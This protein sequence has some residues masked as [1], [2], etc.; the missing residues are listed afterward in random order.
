MAKKTLI[1][2]LQAVE[3][4]IVEL[5]AE[6][7]KLAEQIETEKALANLAAGT[8]I[9][10]NYGRADTRK[11]LQGVVKGVADT[12]KGRRIKVESGEGFDAEIYII[13]VAA[14]VKVVA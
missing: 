5:Q 10:F 11:E 12:D 3:A 2:Q 7:Q 1:E 9:T 8:T 14:I 4:K 13:E 6:A